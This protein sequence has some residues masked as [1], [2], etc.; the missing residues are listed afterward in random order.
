MDGSTTFN[1]K[2]GGAFGVNETNSTELLANNSNTL[3]GVKP[4]DEAEEGEV[5]TRPP[6]GIWA[7]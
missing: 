7:F 2:P 3:L 1:L 5:S 6:R 4:S